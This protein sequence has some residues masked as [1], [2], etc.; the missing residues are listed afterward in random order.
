MYVAYFFNVSLSSYLYVLVL[1]L[2]FNAEQFNNVSICSLFR[3]PSP[4]F[5]LCAFNII[6][7]FAACLKILFNTIVV[8]LPEFIN[9]FNLQVPTN[10]NRKMALIFPNLLLKD[11][12]F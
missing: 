12:L 10:N 5:T 7:L 2:N 4:S 1:G 8:T 11:Y 6:L 9:S 3:K